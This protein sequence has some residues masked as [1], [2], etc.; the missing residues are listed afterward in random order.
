MQNFCVIE[1]GQLSNNFQEYIQVSGAFNYFVCIEIKRKP[2]TTNSSIAITPFSKPDRN[3][4]IAAKYR[5]LQISNEAQYNLN[6]TANFYQ[7]S[8]RD[9]ERVVEA[10]VFPFEDGFEGEC[11][12]RYGPILLDP[13]VQNRLSEA[14]RQNFLEITC[15][16]GSRRSSFP[17]DIVRADN[18]EMQCYDRRHSKLVDTV[19]ITKEVITD[20][21]QVD[22]LQMRVVA[23]GNGR[24]ALP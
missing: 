16:G 1:N 14:V 17:F 13:V 9:I 11:K 24:S 19:R 22:S 5:W 15:E 6:M 7:L 12:I 20:P 3:L 10:T 2:G 4:A 23:P 8:P 18:E 21:S